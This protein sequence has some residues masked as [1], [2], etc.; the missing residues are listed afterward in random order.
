[1]PV[2]DFSKWSP[3]GNTTLFFPA[4]ERLPEDQAT[5]ARLA[6]DPQMLGGEQAGFVDIPGRRLRMA[7][8]EFCLNAS[9][10]FGA[11]LAMEDGGGATC[12]FD[13]NVSGWPCPVSLTVRGTAPRWHVE[14][15]LPLPPCPVTQI[16]EDMRLVRLPGITHVLLHRKSHSVPEDGET[17]LAL[18]RQRHGLADEPCVGGIWWKE[19]NGRLD[20]LP[21]VH[22][23]DTGTTCF[24]NAC[25]SGAL[26]LALALAPMEAMA[27][28]SIRQ[29]G[30]AMLG[31]TLSR[32]GG[33]RTA[34]VDCPVSLVARG[35]F[36]RPEAVPD[37]RPDPAD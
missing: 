28:R 7:G 34:T 25:G 32:D 10:A 18:L 4:G 35:Q 13:V 21:I 3:G 19:Q 9:L 26:A 16:D 15:G 2:T 6:L 31:V 30:G 29:P 8:G 17:A 37:T 20:M 23:R 14:A 24:E 27:R 1:M 5:L 22:V 12:R 11:L 33:R 36:W